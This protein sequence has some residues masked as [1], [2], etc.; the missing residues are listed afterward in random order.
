MFN[1]IINDLGSRRCIGALSWTNIEPQYLR[2]ARIF[3][4]RL[5]ERTLSCTILELQMLEITTL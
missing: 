3:D 4:L 2:C 5:D 1:R